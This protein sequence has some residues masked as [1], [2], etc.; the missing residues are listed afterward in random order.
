MLQYSSPPVMQNLMVDNTNHQFLNGM[1]MPGVVPG[2]CGYP[3][4]NMYPSNGMHG[5]MPAAMP[6]VAMTANPGIPQM[7]ATPGHQQHMNHHPGGMMMSNAGAVNPVQ[8]S[9]MTNG[10][11]MSNIVDQS[12]QAQPFLQ[13]SFV[14]QGRPQQFNMMGGE[15]VTNQQEWL[16]DKE[17]TPPPNRSRQVP[18]KNIRVV[19]AQKKARREVTNK[20]HDGEG[21]AIYQEDT[22]LSID[23]E[24]GHHSLG[25]SKDTSSNFEDDS[26]SECED[27]DG[28]DEGN[29][30]HLDGDNFT[31]VDLD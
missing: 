20:I 8:N 21:T 27:D 28:N 17:Q 4:A 3:G 11:Q 25:N 19:S 24:S 9:M 6:N 10:L 22:A 1:T 23:D 29:N 15:C 12:Q 30:L 13:Q 14:Q 18:I 2:M 26:R 31:D 5:M 16:H 7:M